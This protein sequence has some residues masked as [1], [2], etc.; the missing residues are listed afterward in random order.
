MIEP[1]L[2]AERLL[3]LGLLDQAEE[4][5]RLTAAQDPQN[6]IAVVGLARVAV[7]RGD[8]RLALEHARAALVID[9][10]NEAAIRLVARLEEVLAPAVGGRSADQPLPAPEADRGQ[11]P[12]ESVA[13]ARNP[14]MADHQRR[15]DQA[16]QPPAPPSTPPDEVDRRRGVLDRLLR[17]RP[18][19]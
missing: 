18:G 15:M 2:Q 19:A 7:E 16:N 10:Q 4:L 1:L 5:Y 14:T 3:V 8:D 9:P 11:Q 6:S 13:F 17:R 12:A